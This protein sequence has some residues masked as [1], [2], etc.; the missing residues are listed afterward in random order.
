MI[1]FCPWSFVIGQ[2][3]PSR[4]ARVKN[5]SS[6]MSASLTIWLVSLA[7]GLYQDNPGSADVIVP[8]A[9]LEKVWG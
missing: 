3:P 9:K 4:G 1:L 2:S 7:A 8:G 6:F 5:R